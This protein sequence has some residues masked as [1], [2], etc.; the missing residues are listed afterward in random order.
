MNETVVITGASSGIGE[1]TA[2]KFA[3]EGYDLLL[4]G[5]SNE[6]LQKVK[7]NALKNSPQ[8]KIE[9]L[10]VDLNHFDGNSL[11]FPST[12][13]ILVNNAGVFD[14]NK[15]DDNNI[16]IWEDMFYTNVFGA[17]RIT[18]SLWPIFKK[19]KKGSIVNVSSTLGLKPTPNTSAYS[20][21]KAAMVNWT[22]CLAQEG[23]EFNIRANAVC[24][25]FVDTPIHKFHTL[26]TLEKDKIFE[27]IF[28]M[29]LLRK[30]GK[31][32]H[33]AESVFFFGSDLSS[34]T[35]GAIHSIDGGINIK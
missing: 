35:T 23:G 26:P 20:A 16:K 21:S 1:A 32:D 34:F 3:S 28:E 27:N 4:L 9:T 24:P 10:A 18:Q 15:P 19:N 8:I 7:A 13:T 17:V 22:L 2:Y 25:G 29:Q 5:R 12:P 14:Q 30:I 33:I 31:P 6:R 11:K